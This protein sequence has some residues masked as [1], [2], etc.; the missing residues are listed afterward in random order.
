[1]FGRDFIFPIRKH[2]IALGVLGHTEDR[3]C[4][5]VNRERERETKGA[6][7]QKRKFFPAAAAD[8]DEKNGVI[9]Y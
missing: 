3:V 6:E 8:K 5:C 4:V 1:M 7:G 9:N 2:S